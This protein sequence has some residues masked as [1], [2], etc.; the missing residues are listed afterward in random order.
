MN[1]MWALV[2]GAGVMAGL[3]C[4]SDNTNGGNTPTF[5]QAMCIRGNIAVGGT[6][7][8]TLASSDCDAGD[9]YFES[10]RFNV[11]A[12][13]TIDITMSSAVFDTYLVLLR[14]RSGAE[15]VDSLELVGF[16]DD[17]G[18]GTN[19][20]MS[21]V[22]IAAAEDYLVIANGFDYSDVGAYALS[23]VP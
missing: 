17:G 9:S 10:Y 16:D 23:V 13:T 18:G 8:G 21:N 7:N 12:D 6:V 22:P 14:M 3:A 15:N 19:S 11:A 20:L 1:R 5:Q 4:G 2:A